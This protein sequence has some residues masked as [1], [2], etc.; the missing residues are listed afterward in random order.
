MVS[1]RF[2]SI[3][4][5]IHNLGKTLENMENEPIQ[6]D[7]CAIKSEKDAQRDQ[8][9][10]SRKMDKVGTVINSIVTAGLAVGT[11]LVCP[12]TLFAGIPLTIASFGAAGLSMIDDSDDSE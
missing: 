12:P 8:A 2:E 1:T 7:D 10:L 3:D 5:S 6:R 9:R 11:G 4:K